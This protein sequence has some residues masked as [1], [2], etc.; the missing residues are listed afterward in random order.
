MVMRAGS[1]NIVPVNRFSRSLL[2]VLVAVMIPAASAKERGPAN[3]RVHAAA[4]V[5]RKWPLLRF[6]DPLTGKTFYLFDALARHP[7]VRA[8]L[9][10]DPALAALREGRLRQLAEAA[11]SCGEEIACHVKAMTWS[12]DEVRAARESLESL[13]AR[14][15]LV[16]RFVAETLRPSG[17][18]FRHRSA[19][20]PELLGRAWSDAAAALNRILEVYA[21][22]KPPLYPKIDAVSYDVNSQ[23][24]KR[25]IDV[26]VAVEQELRGGLTTF[27]DPTLAFALRLVRITARD[28]AGRLEPL[29]RGENAP[30][31]QRMS[32]VKWSR[33]PYTAII[34]LGS[35]PDRPELRF[36]P[37][38]RVRL[39]I[40]AARY[41]EG[42]APFLLVSGGYVHPAQTPYNEA[43]E[44]KR[45]L[46]DEFHIPAA[47]ILVEPHARHTTTN[48]RNAARILLRYGAPADRPALVTTDPYHS[49]YLETADFRER[50]AR[51]L[52]YQPGTFGKR[53]SR[54]DVAF[55]PAA[56]SLHADATDPLDP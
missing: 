6:N 52:G 28:E 44:M 22:G 20:D 41:R 34:V 24:Y 9:E 14:D 12:E 37:W 47:A 4:P 13:A 35:G 36:S 49:A 16:S 29:D 38:G 10:R 30:A 1:G 3:A 54:F 5:S 40:A 42:L 25:L 31:L 33:Y 8:R 56:D 18:F 32:G 50:C 46:I 19:S 2:V 48:L 51:E 15:A 53:V 23:S 21:L 43:L 26:S 45:V 17:V 55:V 11:A 27:Y 7:E 39:E